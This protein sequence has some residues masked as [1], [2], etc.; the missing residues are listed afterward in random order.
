MYYAS[1]IKNNRMLHVEMLIMLNFI[2]CQVIET[3]TIENQ[4]A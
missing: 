3:K 2:R 1:V 4:Y